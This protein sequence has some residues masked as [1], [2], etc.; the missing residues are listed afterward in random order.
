[1]G[2]PEIHIEFEEK[3]TNF[4]HRLGRGMVAIA[5][6]DAAYTTPRTVVC[7]DAAEVATAIKNDLP[8][9]KTV[10][11][12]EMVRALNN[13]AAK[14]IAICAKDA[15]TVE[16]AL[17]AQKFNYLAIGNLR[18]SRPD[19]GGDLGEGTRIYVWPSFYCDWQPWPCEYSG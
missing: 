15:T 6:A 13:G 4:I 12:A 10:V 3:K 11:E 8:D 18:P 16:S 1:M 9:K 2:L 7:D 14:V 17:S 5:F 19:H